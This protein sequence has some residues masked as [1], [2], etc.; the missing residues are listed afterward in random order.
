MAD[1]DPRPRPNKFIPLYGL[2]VGAENIKA[3][4]LKD[5]PFDGL[6]GFS[7]GGSFVR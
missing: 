4:I 5:G 7:S 3:K 2:E 6:S 1:E